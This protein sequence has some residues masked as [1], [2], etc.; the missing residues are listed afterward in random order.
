MRAAVRAHFTGAH[1][2]VRTLWL[3]LGRMSEAPID[4]RRPA[5]GFAPVVP[6][7]AV[8]GSRCVRVS[9]CVHGCILSCAST[10]SG[11]SNPMADLR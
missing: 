9:S 2:S 3:S 11:I 10:A 7:G 4:A 6:D 8:E 1:S 5:F